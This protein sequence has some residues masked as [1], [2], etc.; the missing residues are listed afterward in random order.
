LLLEEGEHPV[1]TED[2]PYL[3][4]GL[5]LAEV[6]NEEFRRELARRL[7][8]HPRDLEGEGALFLKGAQ[9]DVL[10]FGLHVAGLGTI[11]S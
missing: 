10:V 6:G 5:E 2:A 1:E 4:K 3:H 9:E 11:R 8:P 7:L